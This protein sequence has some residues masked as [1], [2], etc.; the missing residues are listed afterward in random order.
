MFLVS[1]FKG[2]T[3]EQENSEINEKILCKEGKGFVRERKLK[4]LDLVLLGLP[5]LTTEGSN[6]FTR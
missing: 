4:D 1:V 6:L 5:I 2:F 3:L